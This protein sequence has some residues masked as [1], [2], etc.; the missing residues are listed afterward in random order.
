MAGQKGRDVL[1]R[2]ADGAGH[3][4]TLAGIRTTRFQLSAGRVDATSADSPAAWRELLAG[5]GVKSAKV[6]GAGVFKDAASDARMREVFFA[7]EAPD[8]QLVI[9]GFGTLGG[10]FQIVELIWDGRFDGE[11]GFSVSLESAGALGF[12]PA[13]AGS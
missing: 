7:G 4:E 1:I 2:I 9:P 10:A 8:W 3:F 6:S 11:A 5:A 12:T 13:E